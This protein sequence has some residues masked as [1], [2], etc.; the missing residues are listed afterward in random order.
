MTDV[1]N[2]F[3]LLAQQTNQLVELEQLLKD[4]YEILKLHSP[5]KL[6]AINKLKN[7]LLVKI[8]ATDQLLAAN[9]QFVEDKKNG[10]YS[11]QLKAIENIL[12]NCKS[13]NKVNG[14][15]IH[16]SQLSIERMRTTLLENHTKSTLTYDNKG[17]TSGGLSSLDLKA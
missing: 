11:D 6:V 9:A 5:D 8:D 15:I 2:I 10:N 3:E 13:L 1:T 17:K 7:E 16:K 14:E 12:I 4:E